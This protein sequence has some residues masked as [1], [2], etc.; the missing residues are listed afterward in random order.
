MDKL[1]VWQKRKEFFESILE[2]L[3]R[4][5]NKID[6]ILEQAEYYVS[7]DINETF[8]T[9]ET[10]DCAINTKGVYNNINFSFWYS[11]WQFG[12]VLKISMILDDSNI[13]GA[14]IEDY[15]EEVK[16]LWGK[17]NEPRL[18]VSHG[19]VLYEWEFCVPNLY[20]SYLNQEKFVLGVRHMHFRLL[21]MISDYCLSKN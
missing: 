8:F 2:N 16:F 3:F 5:P 19:K 10:G 11:I 15:F 20:E 1:V 13:Y 21:R 17:N 12:D 4:K 6:L 9:E 18:D 14:V 7:P